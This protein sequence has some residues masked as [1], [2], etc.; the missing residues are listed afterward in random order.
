MI[1][2]RLR[3]DN[4]VQK[5]RQELYQSREAW[6]VSAFFSPGRTN[7]LLDDFRRFIER[8]GT[9]SLILST[10]ANFVKPEHLRHLERFA[11]GIKL[12]VF[13]PPG[14]PFEQSPPNFHPKA[15]L[16]PGKPEE[17]SPL[18]CV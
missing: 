3:R 5:L 9:L 11:P 10:M 17:Q 12:K 8:G 4:L 13:H 16:F 14:I 2:T 6:I 18:H 1:V 15:F 7:L